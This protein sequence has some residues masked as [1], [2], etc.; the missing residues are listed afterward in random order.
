M[1]GALGPQFIACLGLSGGPSSYLI[2]RSSQRKALVPDSMRGFYSHA[3][4]IVLIELLHY[5]KAE[6][7]AFR[8]RF[9]PR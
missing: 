9:P 7:Y 2:F 3:A 8:T 1:N 5:R 4:F 6:A